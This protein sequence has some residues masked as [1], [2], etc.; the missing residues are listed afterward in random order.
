M[1]CMPSSIHGCALSSTTI[2]PAANCVHAA[3]R[4]TLPVLRRLM[5]HRS[6]ALGASLVLFVALV[7]G[8]ADVLAPYD[9]LRSNFRARF[10]APKQERWFG[11]DHFG[12]D[13]L[14]R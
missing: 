3:V 8:F 13:L 2:K 12:R 11:T 9:P 6:F 14:S 1:C 5:K 4:L 7:A 10:I